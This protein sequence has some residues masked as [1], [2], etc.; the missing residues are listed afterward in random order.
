MNQKTARSNKYKDYFDDGT[1]EELIDCCRNSVAR[2]S[3]IYNSAMCCNIICIEQFDKTGRNQS[4]L[5]CIRPNFKMPACT[6][7][8]PQVEF[9]G[10]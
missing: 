3:L 9:F 1:S 8:S 4:T 7:K 10:C 5:K 2:G 6:T